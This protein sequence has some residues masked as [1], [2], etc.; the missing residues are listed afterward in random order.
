MSLSGTRA[1]SLTSSI[2]LQPG[3]IHGRQKTRRKKNGKES[4]ISPAVE[5]IY[6]LIWQMQRRSRHRGRHIHYIQNHKSNITY[7]TRHSRGCWEGCRWWPLTAIAV[8]RGKHSSTSWSDR[9]STPDGSMI[10]TCKT[11]SSMEGSCK[12]LKASRKLKKMKR[13]KPSFFSFCKDSNRHNTW[14][15]KYTNTVGR[16]VKTSHRKLKILVLWLLHQPLLSSLFF[17]HSY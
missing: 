3:D 2:K 14:L 6:S 7:S 9:T 11:K 10:I 17:A 15:K 1:R 12:D 4:Y 8:L 5:K 13:I 16:P